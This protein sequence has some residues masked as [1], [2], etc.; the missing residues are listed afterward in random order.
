MSQNRPKD[1][2]LTQYLNELLDDMPLMDPS[3]TLTD[4]VMRSIQGAECSPK[5]TPRK[6]RMRNELVNSLVATAATLL[7][8]QSGILHKLLTIDTEITQLTAY[9]QHISQYLQS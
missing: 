8:I 3:P 7:L 4:R 6:S 5:V 9:I 1:A 2:Q